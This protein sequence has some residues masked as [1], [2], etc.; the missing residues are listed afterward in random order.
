[1]LMRRLRQVGAAALAAGFCWSAPASAQ[2]SELE[3]APAIDETAL[4][5]ADT[6][7]QIDPWEGFNR[8][9]YGFN[10]VVDGVLLAPAARIYRTVT[11]KKQRKGVRNFLDNLSTP[12]T[13][14]NDILQGEFKR[15]SETAG[16]FVINST[17]GFG[18]M[19]DPAERLGIP[20]HS[21]DFGQTLAVWGVPQGPYL[22]LPVFGPSTIRAGV[23]TG[24]GVAMQPATWITTDAAQ[25][26]RYS[27]GGMTALAVR[28]PLL[29]PLEELRA[30]SLD[31]YASFRSFY[32][33]ARAREIANGRTNFEDLPDIGDF[34]E[35]DDLE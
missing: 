6:V 31:E 11:F 30:N 17:I 1:M 18:G 25:Y 23:G 19:G 28:E 9:V 35:F 5:S 3:G 21:E 22:V 8:K 2:L 32:L 13:L 34:D 7:A 15:A 4:P 24:V 29:E 26:F 10:N 27:T 16:R 20:Q 33:Q 14:V 12:V